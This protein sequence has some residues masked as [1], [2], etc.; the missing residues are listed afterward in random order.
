MTLAL[1]RGAPP[2]APISDFPIEEPSV[3]LAQPTA[4]PASGEQPQKSPIRRRLTPI[5]IGG[6]GTTLTFRVI[7]ELPPITRASMTVT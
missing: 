6:R 5:E 7:P 4:A 1:I 3:K 2:G